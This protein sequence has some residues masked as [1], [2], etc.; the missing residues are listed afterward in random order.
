[1]AGR[2]RGQKTQTREPIICLLHQTELSHKK[3]QK[4]PEQ[5]GKE[6]KIATSLSHKEKKHEQQDHYF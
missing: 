6:N 5:A 3:I 4:N 2:R 1:M